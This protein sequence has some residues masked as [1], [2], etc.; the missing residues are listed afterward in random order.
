M[1]KRSSVTLA[2]SITASTAVSTMLFILQWAS[3]ATFFSWWMK[4]ASLSA[5]TAS[6]LAV[7]AMAASTNVIR[8]SKARPCAR[9]ALTANLYRVATTDRGSKIGS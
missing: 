3:P 1:G 7:A 6:C 5:L 9:T 4:S 8:L 2:V